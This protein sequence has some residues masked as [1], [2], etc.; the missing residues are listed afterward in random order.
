MGKFRGKGRDIMLGRIKEHVIY[1]L[2]FKELLLMRFKLWA[3]IFLGI[4]FLIGMRGGAYAYIMAVG[5]STAF[6]IIVIFSTEDKNQTEVLLSSLPVSRREIVLA[7]YIVILGFALLMLVILTILNYLNEGQYF[8]WLG[9]I[10]LF[11]YLPPVTLGQVM[12]ALGLSL[13]A[14]ALTLPLNFKYGVQKMQAY[15]TTLFG[16]FLLVPT[17]LMV[18]SFSS[19][20]T[21]NVFMEVHINYPLFWSGV[22][23]AMAVATLGLS[24]WLA[25]RFYEKREF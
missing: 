15:N 3:I 16:V 1:K 21:H 22:F 14:I 19:Q 24:F 9:I 20:E 18:R 7:K 6:S 5:C 10:V 2:V 12:V 11:G 17:L 8:Y 4:Y 23:L 13:V 25:I